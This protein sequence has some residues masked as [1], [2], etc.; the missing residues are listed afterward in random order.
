MRKRVQKIK[1][2]LFKKC[3]LKILLIKGEKIP[4]RNCRISKSY[5]REEPKI[6]MNVRSL[7]AFTVLCKSHTFSS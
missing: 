1:G 5:S 2:R 6:T 7:I 3:P 4:W